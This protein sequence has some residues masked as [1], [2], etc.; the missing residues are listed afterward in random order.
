MWLS[1]L[2]SL[3]YPI[4]VSVFGGAALACLLGAW[5]AQR[6]EGADVRRGLVAL[7]STSGLWA[8]AHVGMLL[9][10]GLQWK[11]IFYEAGLVVG[12]GTVW[13]W[14]WLCSAY[15]GRTLHRRR[16]AQGIALLAFGAVTLTKVTNSWHGLYFT[17]GWQTTPFAHLQ[18]D[19]R[20]IYWITA[21]LS[22]ALAAVGFFMVAE[23]LRRV[24]VGAGRL[25]GLFG[26]TA[27][28]LVA[29]GL[30]YLS[31][32]L[33]DVSHE[34]VGV[35]AFAIGALFIYRD[36]FEDA[37]RA[38]A[39][40]KPTLA[41]SEGGQLRN[42]NEAAAAL[43]PALEE[44]SAVG[45]R[46]SDLLPEVAE[47]IAGGQETLQVD[48]NGTA[49]YFRLSQSRY[50]RGTGRQ[51]VLK[52]VTERVLRRRVQEQEHRFLA[53]AVG[54][55]REAVLVTEAGPL[56]EPGPRIVYAN[57]AFEAMT[58]Y[59]EEEVLGRTPRVL[60]GPETEEEVLGSLR[61]ALEAGEQWQGE[62]VN[63]RK[64]GT[65]YV[66][67]WNVAPV[68]GE[69][70]EVQ[71]W[72]SVQRDVAEEREREEQLRRQKGLLEQT[73]RLAG[74]WEVD[75]ETGEGTG[76]EAFYQILEMEGES[77]LTAEKGFQFFAPEARPQIRAAFE[78]CVEA[79]APY[80]LELPVV[81][82]EG[83]RRWV[84]TVGAPSETSE[85][86]V[87]KVA[88]ALQ[89]ITPRKET[90]K[91]LR[92]SR[93][94]LSMAVEGGNV[95][96]WNWDLETDEVIFN[97]RWAEMLGY[98]REELDFDFSTWEALV[99]PEDL[100][101]AL[102]M[103]ETYI[104]GDAGTYDPEIRMRTKSG[105]WKWIQTIGRVV[106]RGVEG[107]VTR[108]AGIHLDIDERKRAEDE[109][110]RSRERYRS[111]FEDSS[112]AILVHDLEGQIQEANPQAE[113]L[114]D[115][116]AGALEG[117]SVH[118]LHP[119]GES[120]AATE[121]LA[122]LRNGAAYQAVARYERAD[123]S[124][125]WGEVSAS[126]TEIG[127]RAVARTLI[128]DVTERVQSRRE[129]EHYREYTDRLLDAID[130]LFLVFDEKATLVR[131][132][133]RVG[134]VTGYADEALA[135]MEAL[136][137]VPDEE[138]ERVASQIADGFMTGYAQMDIPLRRADG[139]T[140][141]YE[142]AGNLVDRPGE[143]FRVVCIGR[144]IT[145]RR[146][147][148]QRLER[149]NDLFER[150]QE[151]A[152]VGAW[153][154]DVRTE[155]S[156]LT[157]QAY[158]IHGL[159]PD[160]DLT[161][162]Q[163][164]A[165]YHPDDRDAVEAAFQGAVEEAEPYDIEVRLITQEGEERWVRTR[166]EPQL[167]PSAAEVANGDASTGPDS[168]QGE[169][170]R[171]RGTVQDITERR[172][173][174]R[175]LEQADTMFRGAQD[176]LFLIDVDH[177]GGEP[178]FTIEKVN[179]AYEE[180]TGMS[181]ESMQ[182]KSPAE[183][184]GDEGGQFVEARYQKCFDQK[185]PL[186]YEEEVLL[187]GKMTYWETRITP[188]LV[189]GTAEKIV[190]STREV[191]G[192]KQREQFRRQRRQKVEALY[193]ATNQLLRAEGKEAVGALLVDLVDETFDYAGTAIRFVEDGRLVPTNV[194]PALQAHVPE[195]HSC[196]RDGDAPV[197]EAYR[198][199]QTQ[200][201][202]DLREVDSA[203][204]RGDI[205]AAAY[206]PMGRH[207]TLSVGSLQV[208]EIESFDRHLIEVITDY[209]TLVLD[210]VDREAVLRGAKEE[211]ERARRK[212]EAASQAKSVFLA[213]MSH[214]IRTPLTSIL[215]F[216][217]AIGEEVGGGDQTGKTDRSD[218]DLPALR[219]F[220]A[221]I[222]SSGERLM[223]TLTGVL[224]LSK[225]EAGEMTLAPEAVDLAAE[226]EKAVQEFAPQARDAGVDLTAEG[227]QDAV[228][229][230]ADEGGVQ[231]VLRNLLSNAVKYT[232]EGGAVRVSAR[233]DGKQDAV[234]EVMDTGIGMDPARVEDLFEPF[235][236][237]SEGLA[238]EYEGTGLGL[239]VTWK[240]LQQM[241][242]SVE[243]ETEKEE[244]S[245][246][247][248]RLPAGQAEGSPDES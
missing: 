89:D 90:E 53:E 72:V 48:E 36:R 117:A 96:T 29:N 136:G 155:K 173:R 169:I 10:P 63:Y 18:I 159:P 51:V 164:L 153:E 37:S 34:P 21:A 215:G 92:R 241:E 174:R 59:R 75:V 231:I 132:N 158:R 58:G 4:Y 245:C 42:Y 121:K 171:V 243:V 225:L 80:D 65:P 73:Q 135:G 122:A 70:G 232:G 54:Q 31:P 242:G 234:L 8:S 130:D 78:R 17:A 175:E 157:D 62:T 104:E 203:V 204:N 118:D 197:A 210:R 134:A 56:D 55:A 183:A 176:A 185:T 9:A 60:Q 64:D 184:I 25:A 32:A 120:E 16:M 101:R 152:N 165:F 188:V 142:I 221:L 23:P 7:L 47:A 109:L 28:P 166:G 246:F 213:N 186:E 83:H 137:F 110:Q 168:S 43:F 74:A 44:Q 247:T 154:Y 146:R 95:G 39:Q 14:V 211:A 116:N 61:A 6:V 190:G 149:Q 170:V 138:R 212:A 209:A 100:P 98:S 106:E 160:R 205:R 86:E 114:F 11:T 235:R 230:R 187:E 194:S 91:K 82:A 162:E 128:Q 151:I 229:A 115:R 224:N 133:D 69:G 202:D 123:G 226:A 87:T 248:V 244:G 192:R 189:E 105:G 68:T 77:A 150:A 161:P 177:A 238:R 233:T 71:H 223:N 129:L 13:A 198:A 220:A 45:R 236:Q 228:W 145:A 216:A 144:D 52:D 26:L 30:G 200:V 139:T 99:H 33:L 214:E 208:G 217:E 180:A 113:S 49:R 22:Y 240:A 88:G 84:R 5:Q 195:C 38:G 12:F 108:A 81:T 196:D 15:S 66:V 206:V 94:Q 40:P 24:R 193:A 97:R 27:L 191:T 147:R 237:E 127:G 20:V 218:V 46:L 143:G 167:D 124:A 126:A 3:A 172:E 79:G 125:F 2:G 76:S 57:E 148:K 222:E 239:A 103:L 112:S 119:S 201:H 50:G 179:P 178:S 199:G 141:P 41:L 219:R 107:A 156:V 111:L 181:E 140:V 35:A 227:C 19:H 207:G 85:G 1:P 163:S 182:G 102:Q 93:E 131:W 67:Q